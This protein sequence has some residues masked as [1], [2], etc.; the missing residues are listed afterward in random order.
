MT[1]NTAWTQF[2]EYIQM[3]SSVDDYIQT[4]TT[5]FLA[6]QTDALGALDGNSI[7]QN[8]V[9]AALSNARASLASFLGSGPAQV[10]PALLRIGNQIGESSQ[11]PSVIA[12]SLREY[13]DDN[14]ETVLERGI[15]YGAIT[16]DGGNTGNGTIYH[17]GIDKYGFV[18]ERTH[19]ET[20][21]YK[22][23]ADAI[24]GGAVRGKE[25]FLIEGEPRADDQLELDNTGKGSGLK[26]PVRALEMTD[27]LVANPSFNVA[28]SDTAPTSLANWAW[29]NAGVIDPAFLGDGT[30]IQ[31]ERTNIYI[32]SIDGENGNPGSLRILKA[33]RLVQEL[34]AGG[35]ATF[36]ERFP[37][38]R[39][40]AWNPGGIA[41]Q[42]YNG[43]ITVRVGSTQVQATYAGAA[44]DAWLIQ[45][46]PVTNGDAW[47][48]NF[49]NG[50]K[51]EFFQIETDNYVSGS[52]L[53][54]H[55]EVCPYFN[56]NGHFSLPFGGPTRF[57]KE[58][59]FEMAITKNASPGK[60]QTFF[61]RFFG[62]DLPHAV[63]GAETRPD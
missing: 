21:K 52:I 37:Y 23:T 11:D 26:V 42:L 19:A 61:W 39:F 32:D 50:D 17:C 46:F 31:I 33:I 38:F 8:R 35:R 62:F 57:K 45:P 55:F 54:D 27:S 53:L 12:I 24:V 10:L 59:K 56:F 43:R 13:F 6:K 2:R 1:F 29:D 63:S 18:I 20:V 49:N 41:G 25:N 28:D 34:G 36:D 44:A 30:D 58:D 51:D 48:D 14:S 60:I 4:P 3:I 16:P 22:C 40:I 5:G 7:E 15:A 9:T 47:P